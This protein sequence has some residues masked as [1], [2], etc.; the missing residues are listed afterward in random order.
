MGTCISSQKQIG[1]WGQ[2]SQTRKSWIKQ[3][4]IKLI[5]TNIWQ[6][7]WRNYIQLEG[8]RKFIESMQTIS[9]S[10][11]DETYQHSITYDANLPVSG[12]NSLGANY[13]ITIHQT[14]F[15]RFETVIISSSSFVDELLTLSRVVI[16]VKANTCRC[17]HTTRV[18]GLTTTVRV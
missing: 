18:F 3:I 4:P 10:M 1:R 5:T 8:L 7:K 15:Q 2:S 11:D 16:I 13:T 9:L 6:V 12:N 14:L 17:T